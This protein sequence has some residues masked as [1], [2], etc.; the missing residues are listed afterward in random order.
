MSGQKILIDTGPLV[1]ILDA[2]DPAHAKCVEAFRTLPAP[3]YTCWPVLTEACYLLRRFPKAVALLLDEVS[4][5][6]LIAL[7]LE[8]RDISEIREVFEIYHDQHVDLADACLV[9]LANRE[10]IHQVFTLDRRHFS[11]FR[12]SKGEVLDILPE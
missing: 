4:E 2:D 11:V 10:R 3:N 9:H 1:A 6:E 7:P 8:P 5:G 12:T